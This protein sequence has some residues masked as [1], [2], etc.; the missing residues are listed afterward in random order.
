MTK[1]TSVVYTENK[2]ELSWSIR[3]SVVFDEN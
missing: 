2:I 3:P 1:R